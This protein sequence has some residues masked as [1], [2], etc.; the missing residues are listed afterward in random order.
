MIAVISCGNENIVEITPAFASGKPRLGIIS[1]T[2]STYRNINFTNEDAITPTSLKANVLF[3][4]LNKKC[5]HTTNATFPIET[6]G[7]IGRKAGPT[8]TI[9]ARNGDINATAIPYPN[10]SIKAQI[11]KT[12][13]THEPVIICPKLLVT[14]CKTINKASK[15][16]AFVKDLVLLNDSNPDKTIVE[17]RKVG[18]YCFD[19]YPTYDEWIRLFDIDE[20]YPNMMKHESAHFEH[21]PVWIDGNAY[22]EGA[23]PWQKE[24]N[25][26]TDASGKVYAEVIE[27]DGSYFLNTNIYEVLGDFK[28]NMISTES[29]GKA[30][31]PQQMYENPDGTPITFDY[32]ILGNHRGTDVIPGPFTSEKTAKERIFA[33]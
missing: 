24:K 25:A 17:N 7:T 20:E 21:L 10:S 29:L 15:T 27:K 23:T 2:T 9:N 28:V 33:H 30:F 8:P 13:L 3:N 19:E 5:K 26:F 4:F 31:E 14:I 6:Q 32:D 18:T 11:A 16:P 12:K 1:T 22:F